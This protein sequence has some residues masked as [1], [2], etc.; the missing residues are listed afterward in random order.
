MRPAT[1]GQRFAAY[2]AQVR[3]EQEAGTINVVQEQE[4]LRDRYWQ[5]CG[6]DADSA[7]HF[8]YSIALMQSAGE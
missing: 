5:I 1:P 2:R 7:G 3:A 6:K 4:T 8:A